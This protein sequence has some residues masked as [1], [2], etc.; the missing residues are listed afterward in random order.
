MTVPLTCYLEHVYP[1][2]LPEQLVMVDYIEE[3]LQQGYIRR[4]TSQASTGFFV[5]KKGDDL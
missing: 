3:A 5:E 4:S 2:S 1:L